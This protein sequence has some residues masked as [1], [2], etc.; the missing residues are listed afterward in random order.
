MCQAAA[1]AAEFCAST[2][3]RELL[4]ATILSGIEAKI[5]WPAVAC[6]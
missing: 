5:A 6:Y 1:R 2:I 3:A 4:Q